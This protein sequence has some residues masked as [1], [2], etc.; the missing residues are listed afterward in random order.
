[1]LLTYMESDDP[2]EE[3][4]LC[5]ACEG[6]EAETLKLLLIRRKKKAYG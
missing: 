3:P 5:R 6:R 2:K 1:M 4:D